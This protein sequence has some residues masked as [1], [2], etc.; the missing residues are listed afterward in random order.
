[1]G[2][3]FLVPAASA[4]QDEAAVPFFWD[5]RETP[6]KPDVTSLPR[7]RFLTTTD[8]RP[9][10]FL[11]GQGRL[12]GF[13]VDLA[14]AICTELGIV[15]RC[16]IQALPW[17]EL[18]PA[19][20][21][22]DGEAILAG[23]AVTVRSRES[24][25]FTR[26]YLRFPARFVAPR[27]S[28]LAEPLTA[29]IQDRRV[30]VVSETAH[31]RLLREEFGARDVQAFDDQDAML[32]ALAEGRLDAAFG[33]GLR[34][35]GWLGT[36]QGSDCCKFA[37]GPYMAPDY[38]GQGLA[39]A[40]KPGDATLREAL[41]WALQQVAVKGTFAELYLRYFPIGFF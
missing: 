2:A 13:H 25:A 41:D 38:L 28:N 34:L 32:D 29:A 22:G 40:T 17:A 6:P 24:L 37:G 18:E 35:A 31:E 26:S 15:E 11:D 21:K 16:E 7:L 8:F 9:F 30:G 36:K 27:A 5:T 33:D 12:T 10:N 4:Q 39:I 19:L 14:R 1:M 23:I 20:H 3:L